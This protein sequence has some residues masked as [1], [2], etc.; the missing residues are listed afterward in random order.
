MMCLSKKTLSVTLCKSFAS[1]RNPEH[2]LPIDH[3][4]NLPSGGIFLIVVTYKLQKYF[5]ASLF[6]QSYEIAT[7]Q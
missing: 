3:N 4:T 7:D 2:K 1:D 6:K 5:E